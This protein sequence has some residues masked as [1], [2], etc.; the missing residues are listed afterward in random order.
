ML[1]YSRPTFY[2]HNISLPVYE[3]T[4][5][6]HH[7]SIEQLGQIL[8]GGIVPEKK[9]CTSQPILVCHNV[10]FVVNLHSL[11]DPKDLRADENGVWK[12]MGAPVAYVSLHKNHGDVPE[13]KR[14]TKMGNLSHN[15]KISRTYYRHSASSD[16][17]R[18]IT[19]VHGM[20]V[21]VAS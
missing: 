8:L 20:V 12:R 6:R 17:H 2:N 16:F 9:I 3:W 18:I 1:H 15:Y 5:S 21:Y 10:A 13:I 19:T 11:D 7:F 14:R 4:H